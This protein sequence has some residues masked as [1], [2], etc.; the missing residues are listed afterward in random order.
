MRRVVGGGSKLLEGLVEGAASERAANVKKTQW[1]VHLKR[2]ANPHRGADARGL[3]G[4]SSK[5]KRTVGAEVYS[6]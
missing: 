2:D 1:P 3:S 6:V 5:P 4:R